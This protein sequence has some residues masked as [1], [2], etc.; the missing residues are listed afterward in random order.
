MFGYDQNGQMNPLGTLFGALFPQK[1]D[2]TPVAPAPID[3]NRIRA[4]LNSGVL[5]QNSARPP[6][7]A[8]PAPP[9]VD[10]GWAPLPQSS[11]IGSALV[12]FLLG[13]GK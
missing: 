8:P 3:Y 4:I 13:G 2:K 5:G 1:E 6:V 11:G 12:K 7:A 10:S 9:P